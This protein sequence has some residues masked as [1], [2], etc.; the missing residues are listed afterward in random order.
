MIDV[1]AFLIKLGDLQ[2]VPDSGQK[3]K[4]A[5]HD[6]CHLA[7][8]QGVRSEPRELL[9]LIPG[10]QLCEIADAHLCCGSAGTYNLDQPEIARSLGQQ[11]VAN[12]LA[13]GADIVA[14]GN[15]GCMTQLAIHLAAT[16]SSITVRHTMQVLRD[17]YR[18]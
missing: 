11:K 15:I 4:L 13:T 18:D 3:R 7:N 14:T 5:Y 9:R 17:A 6:A 16:G 10:A 8:A 2:P 12:V 1:S